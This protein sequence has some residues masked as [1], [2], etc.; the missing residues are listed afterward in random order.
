MAERAR[1]DAL[2]RFGHGRML[3]EMDQHLTEALDRPLRVAIDL[4]ALMAR[5]R[6]YVVDIAGFESALDQQRR[7]SQD[8]RKGKK[9]GVEAD[10]LGDLSQWEAAK[11]SKATE[12][13]L[14]LPCTVFSSSG[15][16]VA[17]KG[18]GSDVRW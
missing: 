3:R 11:G 12:V 13:T 8:E 14:P 1:E 7:R 9:I 10:A 5:E 17:M 4:T 18:A 6:G 16:L 2:S 15:T